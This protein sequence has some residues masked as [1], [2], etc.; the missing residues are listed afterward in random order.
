MK[1]KYSR[2][3]SALYVSPEVFLAILD[4]I[5][6]STLQS[7][8]AVLRNLLGL[9]E[10]VWPRPIKRDRRKNKPPA[11]IDT[12]ALR[13]K[14]AFPVAEVETPGQA[15]WVIQGA[16]FPHGTAFEFV[17]GAYHVTARVEDGKLYVPTIDKLFEVPSKAAM[18]T[19]TELYGD[20]RPINGWDVWFVELA[21]ND[22]RRM[23]CFRPG[24]PELRGGSKRRRNGAAGTSTATA[25]EAKA[26]EAPKTGAE[27][28]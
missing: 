25:A 9:P 13:D 26:P 28:D 11:P 7:P 1:R 20:G 10:G 5:K 27:T 24:E 3:G 8:D 16:V 23:D 21:P 6:T 4:R 12:R 22:W 19:L 2:E 17:R 15:P 14:V 18:D